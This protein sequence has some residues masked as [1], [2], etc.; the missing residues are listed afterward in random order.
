MT[1]SHSPVMNALMT[2]YSRSFCI[3]PHFKEDLTILRANF[4]EGVEVA[5]SRGNT[6]SLEIV[7]F[8]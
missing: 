7:G 3:I 1:H 2:D 6:Q 4:H 5:S 8:E